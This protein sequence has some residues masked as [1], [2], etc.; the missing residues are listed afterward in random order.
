MDTPQLSQLNVASLPPPEIKSDEQL[1]A[2]SVAML[3][4]IEDNGEPECP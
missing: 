3:D 4:S 1:A 2:E